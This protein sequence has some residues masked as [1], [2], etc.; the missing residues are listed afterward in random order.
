[1]TSLLSY[2]LTQ[3][4]FCR[5]TD[6]Q[7]Q[8]FRLSRQPPENSEVRPAVKKKLP[9]SCRMDDIFP[10]SEPSGKSMYDK[11]LETTGCEVCAKC[12]DILCISTFS[13]QHQLADL[14]EVSVVDAVK[15]LTA[16]YEDH[17]NM[18]HKKPKHHI[19]NGKPQ[20]AF[21]F[22]LTKSPKDPLTVGDMLCAVRKVMSQKSC[23]VKRYAWYYEDKGRD[24]HGDAIHPHIHGMYE[25]ESGH[26]IEAKH[27][28]RAWDI[29]NPKKPLG[30]GF[31]GGYHRPVRSEEAYSD[32]IKKDGGMSESKGVVEPTV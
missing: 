2:Y 14:L 32:Y 3:K 6:R 12:V 13:K 15:Q 28:K 9:A 5:P 25:T 19:G 29:W 4:T 17:I 10:A 22:T 21:A 27:W 11:L 18:V 8:Y 7:L 20:G 23:P 1:M 26:Q 24:E 30:S 16:F 31:V